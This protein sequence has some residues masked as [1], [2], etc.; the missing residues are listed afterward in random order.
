MPPATEQG[1]KQGDR[2]S[3]GREEECRTC[4]EAVAIGGWRGDIV[5]RCF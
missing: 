1:V 3:D 4:E 2:G 5:E